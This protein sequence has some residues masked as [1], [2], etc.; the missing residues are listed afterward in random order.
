MWK[1]PTNEY[2]IQD[3]KNQIHNNIG[4]DDIFDKENAKNWLKTPEWAMKKISTILIILALF[5]VGCKS[6]CPAP[7]SYCGEI[8]DICPEEILN[9]CDLMVG[10]I[11]PD[12]SGKFEVIETNKEINEWIHLRDN[13]FDTLI[14][15]ENFIMLEIS[16]E[17]PDDVRFL[18]VRQIKGY[19]EL[20]RR[21]K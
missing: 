6:D 5:L 15:A 7:S 4:F 17:Y 3:L 16:K 9:I 10:E 2:E 13:T 20:Q 18:I 11:C 19:D 8:D 14:E 21:T 1:E 12:Y